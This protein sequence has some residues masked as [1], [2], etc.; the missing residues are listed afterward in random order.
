M[1][2]DTRPTIKLPKHLLES[3][4][5]VGGLSDTSKMPELSWSTPAE[6]CNVGG[7]LRLI[8][9]ARANL[10][11]PEKADTQRLPYRTPCTDGSNVGT[12]IRGQ[13]SR[14]Q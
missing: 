14:R 12:V 10:A 9:G 6:E 1:S 5:L 11:M 4:E 2:K 13:Y 8:P 7:R 3:W